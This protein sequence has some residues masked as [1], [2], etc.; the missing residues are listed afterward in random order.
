MPP[1]PRA[2]ASGLAFALAAY[3]T[4]GLFPVYFRLLAGVPPTEVLAHRVLWCTGFL[5]P[6]LS[7]MGRWEAVRPLLATR[8]LGLL[9]GSALLVSAN[10]LIFI[11]AVGAGHVLDSSLGYFM[12]PLLSVLLGVVFLREPLSRWQ[13]AAVAVAAAGVLALVASVGH[14]PWIALSLA[15]TFGAYGL[16]RKVAG[17]DPVGGLF[18]ETLVL[19]PAAAAWVAWL[20]L[21]GAARFGSAPRPTLLLAASGAVTALPLIWFAS[22]VKRLR[23]STA[24]ILFY[25]NPTMQF[26]VAVLLF[27]EPFSRAH[28]L[29]F[30]CIWASLAIYSADAL[31][32]ARRA[33][34]ARLEAGP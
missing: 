25:V 16:V 6:L 3:V 19:A 4:W 20:W 21:S 2:A 28:A 32:A 33:E 22:G 34:G 9:C 7:A 17:V 29:A 24:G 23:L 8:K 15:L 18:V 14:A 11:W 5:V 26:A 30:A 12:T 13:A 10:W 31:V 27:R 1:R